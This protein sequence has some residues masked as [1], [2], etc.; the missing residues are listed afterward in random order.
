MNEQDHDRYPPRIAP[1]T[2]TDAAVVAYH[3]RSEMR[4]WLDMPRYGMPQAAATAAA[5]G[6]HIR[7]LDEC[8]GTLRQ[9]EALRLHRDVERAER[10]AEAATVR[11]RQA[12]ATVMQRAGWAELRRDLAL[13]PGTPTAVIRRLDGL[14]ASLDTRL[15]ALQAGR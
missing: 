7:A 10:E 8:L 14:I 12:H 9:R 1:T 3:L 15:E 11:G 5:I 2:G 6:R 13:E 4:A